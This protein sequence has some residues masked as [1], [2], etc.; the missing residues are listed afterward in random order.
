LLRVDQTSIRPKNAQP[1]RLSSSAW[2][3]WDTLVGKFSN[4]TQP[5]LDLEGGF[6]RSVLRTRDGRAAPQNL[7]RPD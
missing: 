6:K 2:R 5:S 7:F 3:E 4:M 1:P